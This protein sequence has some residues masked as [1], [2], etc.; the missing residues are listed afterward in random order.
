MAHSLECPV[1]IRCLEVFLLARCSAASSRGKVTLKVLFTVEICLLR[2]T[3]N[4]VFQV[5]FKKMNR[6]NAEVRGEFR[7][8]LCNGDL[9]IWFFH[10][11]PWFTPWKVENITLG[12]EHSKKHWTTRYLVQSKCNIPHPSRDEVQKTLGT[13]RSAFLTSSVALRAS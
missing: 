3:K 1:V 9:I 13:R 7:V 5:V 2:L 4:I 10:D 11:L 8:W 6:A 12:L